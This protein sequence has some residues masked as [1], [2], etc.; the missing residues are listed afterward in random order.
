MPPITLP[1]STAVF[2]MQ[3]IK[4]MLCCGKGAADVKEGA[5]APAGKLGGVPTTHVPVAKAHPDWLDK[6]VK[7]VVP[8]AGLMLPPM[9]LCCRGGYIGA[10]GTERV[11]TGLPISTGKPKGTD[12]P[13]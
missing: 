11:G 2:A 9:P 4:S 12:D 7:Y 13:S 8:T 6:P 1:L 5:N 3:K 10:T